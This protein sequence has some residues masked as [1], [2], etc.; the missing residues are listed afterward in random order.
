[1]ANAECYRSANRRVGL[2]CVMGLVLICV[3]R[4]WQSGIW[5]RPTENDFLHRVLRSV[6]EIRVTKM[7]LH[8]DRPAQVFEGPGARDFVSHLSVVEEKPQPQGRMMVCPCFGTHKL[9]FYR[10]HK[11]IATFSLHHGKKLRSWGRAWR[12][13]RMLTDEARVYIQRALALTREEM[14]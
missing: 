7:E 4:L 9:S 13:D 12:G 8:S 11:L 5:P 10:G 3:V 14:L 6:T 1:M 2:V